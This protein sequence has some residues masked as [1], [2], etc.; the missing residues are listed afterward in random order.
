MHPI[1]NKQQV[2]E[3]FHTLNEEI[4]T[5]ILPAGLYFENSCD[6]LIITEN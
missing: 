6:Q 1:C 4:L 5:S 2:V 3:S